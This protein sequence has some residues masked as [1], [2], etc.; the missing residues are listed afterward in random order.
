M[1]LPLLAVAKVASPNG[2]LTAVTN[3]TTLTVSYKNKQVLQVA[4]ML[5]QGASLTFVRKV[6]ADYQMVAG[7]RLHCTNEANEYRCGNLLLRMYNDGIAF[8]YEYTGLQNQKHPEEQEAYIIPEGTRRWM[9]Q[10]SDGAEGFFPMTTTA[11]VKTL[12]GFWA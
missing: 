3:G 11:E 10:W 12:G 9:M 4:D 6:N 8:R 1:M 2:K 5:T 7:K